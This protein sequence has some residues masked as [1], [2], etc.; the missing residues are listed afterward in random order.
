MESNG[1]ETKDLIQGGFFHEIT[2]IGMAAAMTCM[3]GINEG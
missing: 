2:G 3:E 1:S